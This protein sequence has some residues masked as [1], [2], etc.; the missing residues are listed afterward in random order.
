MNNVNEFVEHLVKI[1]YQEAFKAYGHYPF[2]LF[3]EAKDNSQV[4]GALLL[5]DVR[6][7]YTIFGKHLLSGAKR[8]YMS[9]D[10]PAQGGFETDFVVVFSYEENHFDRFAIPYDTSTGK[11]LPHI[12]ESGHL[13]DIFRQFAATVVQVVPF[14]IKLKNQTDENSN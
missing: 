3:T 12:K 4:I 9:M 13:D 7:L 8:V 11:V 1:E 14:D 5:S 10:F 2:Q 6:E